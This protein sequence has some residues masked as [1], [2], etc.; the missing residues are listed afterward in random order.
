MITFQTIHLLIDETFDRQIISPM[1][2]Y[3]ILLIVSISTHQL[4]IEQYQFIMDFSRFF[5]GLEIPTISNQT[6]PT[7]R[8]M[9]ST[10]ELEL[11]LA[12]IMWNRW[13]K[14]DSTDAVVTERNWV[15]FFWR[16]GS[17]KLRFIRGG[18]GDFGWAR[19]RTL[20]VRRRRS[21]RGR[22]VSAETPTPTEERASEAASCP[23]RQIAPPSWRILP[24]PPTRPDRRQSINCP[25]HLAS[26]T[27]FGAAVGPKNPTRNG[28]PNW[29]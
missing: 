28:C 15:F 22:W 24:V 16:M 23:P 1:H 2:C 11:F 17:R 3:A 10:Q 8:S 27:V 12:S 29:E 7:S 25:S 6:W 21:S 13:W 4:L 26:P 18:T 14:F 20:A 5:F 19:R 9:D